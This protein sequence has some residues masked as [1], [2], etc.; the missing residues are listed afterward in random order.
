MLKITQRI[1]NFFKRETT[2]LKF[3][4]I[5]SAVWSVFGKGAGQIIRVIGNLILT[6]I[7]FPEA[8]GLMATANVVVMVVQLFSDTGINIAIIQNPNGDKPDYLNTAWVIKIFRGILLGIIIGIAAWPI[9]FF[10][11]AAVL[12]PILLIMCLS[13]IVLGFGN[14]AIPVLVKRFKLSRQVLME[15]SSQLVTL[16]STILLAALLKSV[17][18]LAIGFSLGSIFRVTASY[19]VFPY[20]PAFQWSEEAGRELF[21]FG[22]YV[23]LNTLI[24]AAV[25]QLDVLMIG[26][27]LDMELLSFYNIGK[28]LGM[29]VI[30][31]SA[32]VISQSYVPA[33]SSVQNDIERV[34]RIYQRTVSFFL[35]F[36]LPV[37]IVSLLFSR[38]IIRLMYDPRYELS[39]I[40]LFWFALSGI[41][42]TI[43][44]ISG[45]TFFAIGKPVYETIS[46]VIGLLLVVSFIFFGG[47]YYG[48][49]GVSF[50]VAAG[51]SLIPVI[52]SIFLVR[53]IG[54]SLKSILRPWWQSFFVC[55]VCVL[56]FFLLRP[57]LSTN[58][59]S[60]IPFMI[61]MGLVSLAV[62][63]GLYRYLEGPNPFRD[64]SQKRNYENRMVAHESETTI[65]EA[66]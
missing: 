62:S 3:Q 46:M 58:S 41:F 57:W 48:L 54:F 53:G 59:F 33:I 31:F 10:Y 24:T 13:P 17:L 39:F 1:I 4:S 28:T 45:S 11:N 64:Y 47:R 63:T 42:R 52:E 37:S 20:R 36:L 26:K 56:V 19:V 2:S 22:K 40:P 38:D 43:G 5:R 9:S 7:L 55:A 8:F 35:A 12:K 25:M 44:N 61:L 29:L 49:S 27:L 50:A 23:F 16:I 30:M 34:Q 15:I 51:T 18:A 65:S 14:P 60:N 32:N 66:T 21:H 6:R